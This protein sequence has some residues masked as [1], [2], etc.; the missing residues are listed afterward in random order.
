MF[1]LLC[2]NSD[3][4][5]FFN[6]LT[7]AR[8]L[9]R[10]W[11]PRPSANVNAWKNMFDPYS[12]DIQKMPQSQR[13]PSRRTK[14]RRHEEQIKTKQTPHMK[15]PSQEQRRT[16]VDNRLGTVCRKT[17]G[18]LKRVLLTRNLSLNSDAAPN[19]KYMFGPH[20]CPLPHLWNII[21]RHM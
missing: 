12:E 15:P 2:N 20:R 9:G 13:S 11:K 8:S 17:S 3:R 19:H 14:R 10:C 7:F 21:V 18:A 5:W 4:T 6:A 16:I 1:S